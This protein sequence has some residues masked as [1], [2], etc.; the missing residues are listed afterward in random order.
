[1]EYRY[2]T[3]Q[4]IIHVFVLRYNA[5]SPSIHSNKFIV[6]IAI[7]THHVSSLMAH[8]IH[9]AIAQSSKLLQYIQLNVLGYENRTTATNIH[10]E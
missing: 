4:A 1:M 3:F 5:S 8:V 6:P 7:Y 10:L 9:L 2:L